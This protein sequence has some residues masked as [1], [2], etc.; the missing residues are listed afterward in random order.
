MRKKCVV[1]RCDVSGVKF[2]TVV[3]HDDTVKRA[4]FLFIA[5]DCS[6]HAV[7]IL[8]MKCEILCF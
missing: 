7:W 4:C 2:D 8:T 1:V 3:N 6:P 5:S